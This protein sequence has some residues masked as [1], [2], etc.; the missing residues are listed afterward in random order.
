MERSSFILKTAF[1]RKTAFRRSAMLQ[2]TKKFT[3]NHLCCKIPLLKIFTK[4]IMRILPNA[5]RSFQIPINVDALVF[6]VSGYKRRQN[7]PAGMRMRDP[8]LGHGCRSSPGSSPEG[9]T[10]RLHGAL[11]T[12]WSLLARTKT[13]PHG[14]ILGQIDIQNITA[15][16]CCDGFYVDTDQMSR[17][18]ESLF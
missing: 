4:K 7:V 14:G 1:E 6:Q 10:L 8:S 15:R 9:A 18:K 12:N 5:K 3:K 11:P 16:L 13:I 2:N 17:L